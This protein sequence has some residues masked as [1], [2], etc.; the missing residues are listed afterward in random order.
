MEG[1]VDLGKCF[2]FYSYCKGMPL[3]VLNKEWY[4]P[5][6]IWGRAL[7]LLR[8]E[9]G[10][11]AREAGRADRR[12]L[13]AGG[14]RLWPPCGTGDGER[15]VDLRWN[16]ELELS[17]LD[18]DLNPKE[19]GRRPQRCLISGLSNWVDGRATYRLG[20]IR[21]ECKQKMKRATVSL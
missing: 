17:G 16:L 20:K 6:S 18:D 14:G 11:R 15:W 9:W 21:G 19:E 5:F 8:G 1:P 2:C 10:G 13:Y 7:W 4:N 3:E 12:Q